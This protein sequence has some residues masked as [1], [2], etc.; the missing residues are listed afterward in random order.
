LLSTLERCDLVRGIAL[1]GQSEF[2]A[3]FFEKTKRP[4]PILESLELRHGRAHTLEFPSSFL[5]GSAPQL[6]CLKVDPVSFASISGILSSATMLVEL[7]LETDTVFGP[8]PEE[9]LPVYLQAMP[10]LRHLELRVSS[11]SIDT[12][13]H[14]PTNPEDIVHLPKLTTFRYYGHSVFLNA[15]VAGFSAPSL[16]ELFVGLIDAT[17]LPIS[18]LPRFIDGLSQP[19]CTVQVILE[20]ESFRLSLLASDEFYDIE[21]P[22]FKFYATRFPESIMRIS[23]ALAAKLATIERLFIT[24]GSG[25]HETWE[26]DIPWRKFLQQFHSVKQ[27]GLEGGK[28]P[29]IASAFQPNQGGSVFDFLPALESINLHTSEIRARIYGESGLA[30]EREAFQPFTSAR[31]QAGRPIEVSRSVGFQTSISYMHQF[32]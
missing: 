2:F 6:Q 30:Y 13:V 12:L 1:K 16:Q 4:F 10:C 19:H 5:G 11:R 8:Q 14:L 27:I 3:E 23:S 25:A 21:E 32:K 29:D 18:H 22:R 15:L 7:C 26:H 24:F 28:I 9:S 20:R 17:S 31:E